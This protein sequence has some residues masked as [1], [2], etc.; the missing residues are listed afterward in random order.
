MLPVIG[1]FRQDFNSRPCE[2][3]DTASASPMPSTA[4]FNSRP[5]ER[6]DLLYSSSSSSS[7]SISILAPARGATWRRASPS[8][9]ARYFNSRPCERGDVSDR[10]RGAVRSISI[11][12]PAR[13]ATRQHR[14]RST[15]IQISILAPAR[16]AT[17]AGEGNHRGDDF[18]SRPCER[19]DSNTLQNWFCKVQLF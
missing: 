17:R 12:A 8:P 3:G 10:D 15:R 16:G 4:Y 5:C 2:R 14:A 6:G 9:R 18:N 1:F 19:G 7:S 11:L 13:G